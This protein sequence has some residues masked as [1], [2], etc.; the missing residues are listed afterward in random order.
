M[1][2]S[3]SSSAWWPAA[4][5]GSTPTTELTERRRPERGGPG[6]AARLD[7]LRRERTAAERRVDEAR[8]RARRAELEA[9]EA[10]LRLEAA[11]ETLRRELESNRRWLRPPGTAAARRGHAAPPGCGTRARAPP[12]RAI[13]PLAL[14]EYDALQERHTFLETQL[15]DVAP[16]AA[17]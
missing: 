6:V 7:G 16:P 9:A 4:R 2:G 17:S 3:A 14:E 5:G 13:N 8:E 10:R 11:V 15:E 1:A 12:A